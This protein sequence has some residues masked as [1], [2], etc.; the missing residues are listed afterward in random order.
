LTGVTWQPPGPSAPSRDPAPAL[1][2]QPGCPARRRAVTSAREYLIR[3]SSSG[4]ASPEALGRLRSSGGLCGRHTELVLSVPGAAA[5]FTGVYRQLVA[6]AL[7]NLQA[8]PATCAACEQE[9][10]AGDSVLDTLLNNLDANERQHYK[11]HGSLCLPHLRRAARRYPGPNVRWLI[12]FM[13]IRLTGPGLDLDLL[14]GPQTWPAQDTT[15]PVMQ[16]TAGLARSSVGGDRVCGP[17]QAAIGAQRAAVIAASD[18]LAP[19][20]EEK[21]LCA[22]HLHNLALAAGG[23]PLGPLRRQALRHA[24]MLGAVLDGRLRLLGI[25]PGWQSPRARR[26][27][28]EPE[29]PACRV[30]DAAS[31]KKLG[32]FRLPHEDKPD[33]TASPLLCL[34]HLAT[35]NAIDPRAGEAALPAATTTVTAVSAQLALA[36]A[37]PELAAPACW[38]AAT[39]LD[40]SVRPGCR[41]G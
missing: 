6:D 1:L 5:R 26:A 36:A 41:A 14:A 30:G 35:L 2:G 15:S 3:L 28:A 27:L 38:R 34:R 8:T 13:I 32:S 33:D 4:R 10:T 25:S 11:L 21:S 40:G 20:A 29:C 22:R 24:R 9:E 18:A 12:R 16:P 31:S 37:A 39:F 19:A 23:A 17:C 7:Q